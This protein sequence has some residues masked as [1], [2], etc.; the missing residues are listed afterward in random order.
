MYSF[1]FQ[2]MHGMSLL[3]SL[4]KKSLIRAELIAK[5]KHTVSCTDIQPVLSCLAKFPQHS[6]EEAWNITN[7]CTSKSTLLLLDEALKAGHCSQ[8]LNV[9]FSLI[10]CS[11]QE[12]YLVVNTLSSLKS[13]RLWEEMNQILAH[14]VHLWQKQEE[15]KKQKEQ[16]EESLYK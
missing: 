7:L 5:Q 9:T 12:I 11:L 6:I 10:R 16:E 2:V 4:L 13:N 15:E 8:Q 14:L 1:P 3:S